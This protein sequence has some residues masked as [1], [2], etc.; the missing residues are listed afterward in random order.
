MYLAGYL[1]YFRVDIDILQREELQNYETE[2][3]QII[4]ECDINTIIIII[5]I[6]TTIIILKNTHF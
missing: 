5:T 6:S 4:P 1:I 3:S 2:D